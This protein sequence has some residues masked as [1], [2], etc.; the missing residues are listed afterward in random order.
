MNRQP[1]KQISAVWVYWA[2]AAKGEELKYS[3]R[4]VSEHFT[5]LKNIVLC[6][7]LPDW[8]TG[9]F[10]S[11]PKFTPQQA[12]EKFGTTRWHKCV[13]SV[14]K[15]KRIIDS[16][17]VTEQF[18]WLY[19]DTFFIRDITAA[20]VSIHRRSNLLCAKPQRK[21]KNTWREGLRRTTIALHEAG[22]P[23]WNYSHH[24]PVVYDKK[25]LQQ[26]IDK[27]GAEHN[28]RA[29]ESLYVNHHFDVEQTK[30]LGRWMSYTQIPKPNWR[31]SPHAS[32]VN[33]GVFNE[34]VRADICYRFPNPSPIETVP[35]I[36]FDHR[37][38]NEIYP[39]EVLIVI[40]YLSPDKSTNIACL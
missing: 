1:D 35:V 16:P 13:D 33:V 28:P 10:I 6:G 2:G 31:P 4:S 32:M 23:S 40:G 20:E 9:D 29:I 39:A 5:G 17:L 22:R 36:Q 7:D 19:D 8:Y 3:M 11:S 14:I 18:L 21:T 34:Y 15:L 24:G 30:H 25:L 26:T 38:L 12:R 37:E 27:F